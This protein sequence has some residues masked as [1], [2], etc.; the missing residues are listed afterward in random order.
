M[1]GDVTRKKGRKGP[2]IGKNMVVAQGVVN[3]VCG[4]NK[5]GRLQGGGVEWLV[6]LG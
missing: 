4:E 3:Y 6:R 1:G 5:T 2:K